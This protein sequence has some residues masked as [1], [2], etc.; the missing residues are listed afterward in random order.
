MMAMTMQNLAKM[1][2]APMAGTTEAT[3]F[4]G[5]FYFL[6]IQISPEV[7]C[8]WVC[9]WG[10]NTFSGGKKSECAVNSFP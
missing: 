2:M 8:L 7:C 10:P 3:G 6:D 4:H 1:A 5:F 9:F